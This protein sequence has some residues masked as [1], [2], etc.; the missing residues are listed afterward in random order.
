MCTNE[1]Y[2]YKIYVYS[3]IFGEGRCLLFLFL[4][5]K[6]KCRCLCPWFNRP[7]PSWLNV[8]PPVLKDRRLV[9][10]AG[11]RKQRRRPCVGR[12]S[13]APSCSRRGCRWRW[14]LIWVWVWFCSG[15]G[16]FWAGG[17]EF[18]P[19]TLVLFVLF[20]CSSILYQCQ[21]VGVKSCFHPPNKLSHSGA[22]V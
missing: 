20:C 21:E 3:S 5:L 19:V 12:V 18:V 8:L 4:I 11:D 2:I 9:G 16:C 7:A 14:R 6:M 15:F 22:K 1:F 17:G 10:L 13:Q